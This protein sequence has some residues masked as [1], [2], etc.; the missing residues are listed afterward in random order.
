MVTAT[1]R[2]P[3]SKDIGDYESAEY[4]EY[5]NPYGDSSYP[6]GA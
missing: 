6:S 3:P 1:G 5:S 2:S 4:E